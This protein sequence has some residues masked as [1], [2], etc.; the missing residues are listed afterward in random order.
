MKKL[1]E[2]YHFI[3]ILIC[4]I[5]LIYVINI[6]RM[7][8]HLY[9]GMDSEYVVREIQGSISDS[10]QVITSAIES[11]TS[12]IESELYDIQIELLY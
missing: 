12:D 11:A 2:Y 1:K 3:V 6:H 5:G 9:S 4:S 8:K 7:V 10:E